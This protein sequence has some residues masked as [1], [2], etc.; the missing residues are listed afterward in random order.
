[1]FDKKDLDRP[2]TI[3]DFHEF[4]DFASKTFITKVDSKNFATKDDLRLFATKDD[5]RDFARKDDLHSFKDQILTAVDGVMHEVKAMR[6]EQSA[7]AHRHDQVDE[8]INNHERRLKQVENH[9]G[10]G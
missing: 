10:I 5:L 2:V 3:R 6:E 8:K 1:M 9:A 4:V 7:H